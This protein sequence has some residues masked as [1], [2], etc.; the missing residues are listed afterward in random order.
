MICCCSSAAMVLTSAPL[1][2]SFSLI[3]GNIPFDTTESEVHSLL[4]QIGQIK[5]FRCRK[6]QQQRCGGGGS[7]AAGHCILC[8]C[9]PLSSIT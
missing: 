1:S 9:K 4:S 3:V 7:R 8:S 2:L 6:E 5:N